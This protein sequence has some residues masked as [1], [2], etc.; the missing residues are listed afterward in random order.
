MGKDFLDIQYSNKQRYQKGL[1]IGVYYVYMKIGQDLLDIQYLPML[2]KHTMLFKMKYWWIEKM[3]I[4][5]FR[6]KN[7]FNTLNVNTRT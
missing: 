5:T 3:A 4:L 6:L 1:P 7:V 2:Q